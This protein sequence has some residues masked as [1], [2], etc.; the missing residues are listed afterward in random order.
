MPTFNYTEW[1]SGMKTTY[2]KET[3]VQRQFLLIDAEGQVLGRL[4]VQVA[5]TLRG[6]NKPIFQPSVDCGDYVII[7]NADK[8]RLTGKK[9]RQKMYYRHSGYPGGIKEIPY[10]VMS[11]KHPDRVIRMAV[12][13]MLPQNRLG[14]QM[15]RKL[16]IYTGTEHPHE[17]QKPV[18]V[19][20]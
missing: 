2:T 4:A 17:A 14:K 20:L 13:G 16:K 7:V 8:V 3:D 10:R 18:K 9:E 6:K 5:D 1:D 15:L 12:K 11:A 19:S